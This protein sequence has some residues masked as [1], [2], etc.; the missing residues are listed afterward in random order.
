MVYGLLTLTIHILARIGTFYFTMI[1]LTFFTRV[2]I[3]LFKVT[4]ELHRRSIGIC[5]CM[6]VLEEM[7]EEKVCKV[8]T[9]YLQNSTAFFFSNH[10]IR[11]PKE[12]AW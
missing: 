7:R 10:L 9:L 11:V 3:V 2:Y 5:V 6:C 12:I 4:L 1:V 8:P